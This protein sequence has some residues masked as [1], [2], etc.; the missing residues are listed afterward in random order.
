MPGV[1][2]GIKQVMIPI[3]KYFQ[4]AYPGIFNDIYYNEDLEQEFF[5][6][7]VKLKAETF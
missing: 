6:E 7:I 1:Q 2:G 3:L 5:A 4:E